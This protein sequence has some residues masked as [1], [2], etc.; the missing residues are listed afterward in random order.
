MCLSAVHDS[1]VASLVQYHSIYTGHAPCTQSPVYSAGPHEIAVI[2]APDIF[3]KAEH[4]Y[5]D[6]GE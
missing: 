1:S 6:T 2:V 4:Q 3:E 5:E